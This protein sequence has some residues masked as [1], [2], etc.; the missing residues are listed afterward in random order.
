MPGLR[1]PAPR[2]AWGRVYEATFEAVISV[3]LAM[4][5]GYYAD[6]NFGTEPIFLL[7]GL[8][9]GGAAATRR[10]LKI[11]PG[12]STGPHTEESPSGESH[13]EGDQSAERASTGDTPGR[14][15]KGN[16]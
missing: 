16:G 7:V 1:P 10:L 3:V 11:G 5:G 12:S 14:D 13:P 8:V 2:T 6:E 4:F 9:L 15:G